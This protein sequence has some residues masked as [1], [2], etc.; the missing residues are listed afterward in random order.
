MDLTASQDLVFFL[1]FLKNVLIVL[2]FKE[3]FFNFAL[4]FF[5]Y[6]FSLVNYMSVTLV[7]FMKDTS[8]HI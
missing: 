5:V 2:E 8:E 7:V 3:V 1:M 4:C 6:F